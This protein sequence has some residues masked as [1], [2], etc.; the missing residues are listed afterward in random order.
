MR[1]LMRPAVLLLLV[2]VVSLP[3]IADNPKD[4]Y[5]KGQDAES[6][7]QYEAAYTFFKKAYDLKPKDIRY[8]TAFE[9]TRFEA[10]AA[11]VHTGQKLRDEGKLDDAVAQ[12]QKALEI[13]PSLF[14]ARQELDRTVKMI[15]DQ[16]NPPPQ[17]A[18]PPSSLERRVHEAAGPVEL[19]PISNIPITIKM[20]DKSDTVYRTV[21]QLA[22]IN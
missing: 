11:I 9:R 6:R 12:F 14:I 8:R 19:T 10:A 15:N 17:A 2:A 20:T 13:D 18:G 16:R 5:A 3:A 4:L 22:G 7:Q 1:R 21:G